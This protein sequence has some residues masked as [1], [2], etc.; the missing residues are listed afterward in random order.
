MSYAIIPARGGSKRVPRKNIREFCGQPMISWVIGTALSSGLFSRVIV[1][2]DDA[3]IAKVSRLNGAEV[4]DLR[5]SNL[6][7]DFTPI[8]HVVTEAIEQFDL[9]PSPICLLYATSAG[10]TPEHLVEANKSFLSSNA[11]D[12]CMAVTEYSHPIQ[13]RVLLENQIL[14]MVEPENAMIRTQDLRPHYHDA[15]Q[16]I[17]GRHEAWRDGRS[18]WTSKTCGYVMPAHCALDIDSEDDWVRAERLLKSELI[19]TSYADD[20]AKE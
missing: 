13:R 17:F 7:D 19:S 2:T 14:K 3:E 20:G 4:P 5:P 16:F 10:L 6:A 12:F 11:S 18:V 15:G 9:S 8:T 1:S